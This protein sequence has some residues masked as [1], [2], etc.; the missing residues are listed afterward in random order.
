MYRRIQGAQIWYLGARCS[1]KWRYDNKKSYVCIYIH[2]HTWSSYVCSPFHRCR[3]LQEGERKKNIN[4]R[5]KR[6]RPF[7]RDLFVN[8]YLTNKRRKNIQASYVRKKV[9]APF[10]A[11]PWTRSVHPRR[12]VRASL[13]SRYTRSRKSAPMQLAALQCASRNNEKKE[14]RYACKI[15][16]FLFFFGACA[17]VPIIRFCARLVN[18]ENVIEL[19]C[20]IWYTSDFH[21]LT[22][23]ASSIFSLRM[24]NYTGFPYCFVHTCAFCRDE[25]WALVSPSY[26]HRRIFINV[27]VQRFASVK[28][29]Y[30]TRH[31]MQLSTNCLFRMA[32]Y[33]TSLSCVCFFYIKLSWV[34]SCNFPLE[35]LSQ[36]KN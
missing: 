3:D 27:H 14:R 35:K 15:G 33:N 5:E 6:F 4:W 24:R 29:L 23:F 9:T 8:D 10:H 21:L 22:L 31:F 18:I 11:L 34:I 25:R 1:T 26:L 2:I 28:F 17:F 36:F 19:P 13:T 20:G 30:S 16:F 12:H 32:V 7:S